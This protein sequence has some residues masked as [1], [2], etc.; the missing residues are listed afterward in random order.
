MVQ[1]TQLLLFNSYNLAS[2]ADDPCQPGTVFNGHI[3]IPGYCVERENA[4]NKTAIHRL[5]DMAADSEI[6]ELSQ[7]VQALLGFLLHTD[8]AIT[9]TKFRV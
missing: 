1:V 9:E 8:N 7:Q 5:K 6:P 4:L 2:R 3:S